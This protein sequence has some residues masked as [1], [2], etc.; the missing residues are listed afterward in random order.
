MRSILCLALAAAFACGCA[1]EQSAVSSGYGKPTSPSPSVVSMSQ[2]RIADLQE[3]NQ[4]YLKTA[5][6]M[7]VEKAKLQAR[8]KELETQNAELKQENDDLRAATVGGVSVRTS[9]SQP[10]VRYTERLRQMPTPSP[11]PASMPPAGAGLLP[12]DMP[13]H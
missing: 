12:S 1:S 11:T 4:T 7:A 9:S 6:A 3:Q 2:Q 13:E 5:Q 8:V 10:V